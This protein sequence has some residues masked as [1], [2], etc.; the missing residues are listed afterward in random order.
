M[1]LCSHRV[2][3]EDVCMKRKIAEQR[4]RWKIKFHTLTGKP[5]KKRPL[6]RSWDPSIL[7]GPERELA[8]GGK[9]VCAVIYLDGEPEV[10]QACMFFL[11]V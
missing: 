10:I 8:I 6:G 2:K 5:D 9:F 1:L 11:R 7:A 3:D 4:R